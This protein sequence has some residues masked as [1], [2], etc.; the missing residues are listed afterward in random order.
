[1]DLPEH[2]TRVERRTEGTAVI[3]NVAR[4]ISDRAP[5]GKP[6]PPADVHTVLPPI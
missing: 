1:M 5:T 3:P 4:P 2:V 6:R